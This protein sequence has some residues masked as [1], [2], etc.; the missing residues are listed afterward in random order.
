LF[1]KSA[2][3]IS[4]TRHIPR[5]RMAFLSGSDGILGRRNGRSREA[6]TPM[7]TTNLTNQ[8]NY[9]FLINWKIRSIRAISVH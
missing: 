5:S 3:F 8:T 4:Q 2:V 9:S 1:Q 7:S 6:P